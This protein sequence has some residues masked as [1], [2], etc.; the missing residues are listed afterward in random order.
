MMQWDNQGYIALVRG[1]NIR[2]SLWLIAVVGLMV[3]AWLPTL[4]QERVT[5]EAQGQANLRASPN[6]ESERVGE[7]F[8]GVPYPV[9]GRSEFFPWVLLADPS[10]LQIK[11]WVFRDLVTI[12]GDLNSVP[13]SSVVVDASVQE[14][15]V[16][17]ATASATPSSIEDTGV[18]MDTPTPMATPTATVA[19]NVAGV[20]RGEINIRYGPGADYPRLGVAQ[21]GERY[22]ITGYHTQFP[23]VQVAYEA[24]PNGSGWIAIDLLEIEGNIF[25][26]PAIMETQLR[27]PTLTPTPPVISSSQLGGESVPLRPEFEQL[28]NDL[29]TFVLE[30]GFDPATSRFGA[31]FIMDLQ[32]REAITFGNQFAFSGTSIAKIGILAR[33]YASLNEAPD[34]RIATDIAN[35]MI[36]SENMATN[37]LLSIIG[38]GDEFLGAE[39]VTDLFRR[40]GLENSFLT[41]PFITD[42]NNP[43]IPPR[44]IG[45]PV[46]NVD[47]R[48]ANPDLSNQITVED[49]GWLLAEIY[50]CAYNES[51]RLMEAYPGLYESRECRQ[52]LH[53]MS[54]NNVDALLRAGVPEEIRV[55]HKHGWIFDTHGNAALFFT[56]GGDYIITMMLHQPSWLIYDESLPVI[57]D[58]SR[59]VFNFYNPDAPLDEVREGF[60]PDAPTCN[61]ANTPLILDLRQPVWDD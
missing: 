9:V 17:V 31:L 41:S 34:A 27:L 57:A 25:S 37:R 61:F 26:L 28:G 10:T 59:R 1:L 22:Q 55:A 38:D 23:W 3:M 56:P 6:V 46:T 53:V 43:P 12:T 33:L 51:G 15:P 5:A 4:A 7:I 36:C 60:I 45:I 52:M 35:T 47:Q 49:M 42:P 30:S 29:W 16:I 21:A 54:S 18:A 2:W 13:V 8:A 14:A 20:A 58:V 39:R 32:T 44:P 19:F 50:D 48:K 24:S 11:G 40:L